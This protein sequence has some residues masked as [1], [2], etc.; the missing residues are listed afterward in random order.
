L[1]VGQAG[2]RSHFEAFWIKKLL[3]ILNKEEEE[4]IDRFEYLEVTTDEARWV[5]EVNPVSQL[6]DLK[7]VDHHMFVDAADL[8]GALGWEMLGPPVRAE[9]VGFL[10]F[11]KRIVR[12]I[13]K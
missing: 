7:I 8:L 13:R 4:M 5:M 1:P 9:G 12:G 3:K 2:S 11:F 10:F 6:D